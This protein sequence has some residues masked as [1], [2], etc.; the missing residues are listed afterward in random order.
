MIKKE[1]KEIEE[2]DYV[3]MRT[4]AGSIGQVEAVDKNKAIV[5]MGQMR[6]TVPLRDLQHARA[7]LEVQKTK[8]IHTEIS[9][10]SK[11]E[12]KIDIR[13][14]RME[15]ALKVMEEFV[16]RALMAN[17]N[18]LQVVHGKGNGVL[19]KAVRMKLEEYDAVLHIN[20]PEEE[21]GGNGV[22]LVELR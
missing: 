15:E 3:K 18:H 10:T 20:H 14:M 6:V 12:N 22:T 2:G 1:E 9:Q 19:R 8:S 7:P 11:F 13:G 16:D 21:Q 4:G 5:L 17:V